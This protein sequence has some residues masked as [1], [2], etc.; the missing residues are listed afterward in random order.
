MIQTAEQMYE[1][2]KM[3]PP[4]EREKLDI[5]LKAERPNGSKGAMGYRTERWE[6][7]QRWIHANKEK[8]DGQFVLLEGDELLGHGS[9]PR[10]LYQLARERG[11]KIPYVERIRAVE[12]P[13]FGGW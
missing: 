8:Y 4:D 3:L 1:G 13:F 9:D 11:I 12:E 7:S 10:A 5:L 2:I 6:R